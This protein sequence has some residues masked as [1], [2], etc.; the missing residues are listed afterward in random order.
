MNWEWDVGLYWGWRHAAAL[1]EW[2][3]WG[4]VPTGDM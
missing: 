1:D 4:H 2:L 3:E